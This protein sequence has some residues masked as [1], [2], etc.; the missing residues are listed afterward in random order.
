[1]HTFLDGVIFTLS[2]LLVLCLLILAVGTI[3]DDLPNIEVPTCPEDAVLVGTGSYSY[4]KWTKYYCGPSVDD[5]KG[6]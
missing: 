4:N 5:Y 1:M 2:V 6:Y 3:S